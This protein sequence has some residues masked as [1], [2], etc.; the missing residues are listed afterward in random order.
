M[1][2]ITVKNVEKIRYEIAKKGYSLR[3]FAKEINVSHSYLSQVINSKYS[4]SPIVAKKIA[5]G[6]NREIEDFFLI[7][8]VGELTKNEVNEH[9]KR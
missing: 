5:K 8:V 1:I 4:P 9:A 6:L 7:N 2:K 3:A